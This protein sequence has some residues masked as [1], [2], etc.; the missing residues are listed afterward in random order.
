LA[1]VIDIDDILDLD[2]LY[3]R[4]AGTDY[5]LPG[6]LPV[7]D[8]LRLRRDVNLLADP[9]SVDEDERED[10]DEVLR[11]VADQL[12]S[13]LREHQPDL[14]ELPCGVKSVVPVAYAYVNGLS[15]EVDEEEA[16]APPTRRRASTPKK[17]SGNRRTTPTTSA[18]R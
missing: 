11:R 16:P 9:E 7:P 6:D 5:Q 12:L 18:S 15:R 8:Y 4:I 14:A 10:A 13:M 2:V 1:R 3:V 17:T